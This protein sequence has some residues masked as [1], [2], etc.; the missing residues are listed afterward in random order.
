MRRK[1]SR[2]IK[3]TSN[4]ERPDHINRRPIIHPPQ[5]RHKKSH[6]GLRVSKSL[7]G[8]AIGILVHAIENALTQHLRVSTS[9]ENGHS[10]IIQ[11]PGPSPNLN[12]QER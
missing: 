9:A 1:E 3:T 4:R 10:L 2:T 6:F 12:P 5:P 7:D 8:V 11:N